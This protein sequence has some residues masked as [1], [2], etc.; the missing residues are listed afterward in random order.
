MVLLFSYGTLRQ[1]D[2]QLSTFGRELVGTPDRLP[3]YT[4]SVLRIT[5]PEVVAVS[6]LEYHPVVRA[7]GSPDDGVEGV[8]FELTDAELASADEYEVA[9]YTRAL[10][11]LVSGASAWVYAATHLPRH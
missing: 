2:V 5:D 1:R 10:V 8:A 6:G 3:G 4:V 9:D 11:P 7:T